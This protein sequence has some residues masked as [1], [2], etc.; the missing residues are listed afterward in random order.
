MV[1]PWV[2]HVKQ[3]A[4]QNNKTYACAIPEAA[5]TYVKK[6]KEPTKKE[7][8]NKKREEVNNLEYELKETKNRIDSIDMAKT[9]KSTYSN[10]RIS[11]TIAKHQSVYI[12][13]YNKTKEE[14]EKITGKKYSAL[15]TEKEK[16]QST[17]IA[18]K[19]MKLRE[20]ELE[21]N[22]KINVNKNDYDFSLIRK[23]KK[24]GVIL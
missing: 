6:T 23:K 9:L 17:K 21:K 4:K 14:L 15:P 11:P 20:I 22:R 8:E 1:N 18:E 3:F 2:E 5:K 12:N 13:E 19:E 10:R 7:A 16:K 24:S